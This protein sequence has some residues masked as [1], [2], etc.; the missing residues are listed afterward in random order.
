M[1]LADEVSRGKRDRLSGAA[2]QRPEE[3]GRLPVNVFGGVAPRICSVFLGA[4]VQ[5]EGEACSDVITRDGDGGTGGRA[6][7]VLPALAIANSAGRRMTK[8]CSAAM[9]SLVL[10]ANNLLDVMNNLQF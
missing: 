1:V 7:E 6:P 10:I 5:V 9:N 3:L 8:H 4:D 2:I